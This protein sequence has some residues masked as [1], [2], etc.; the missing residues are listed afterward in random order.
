MD[1]S[2]LHQ[3]RS[4]AIGG[5]VGE[6]QQW[7]DDKNLAR[8]LGG[9]TATAAFH[10]VLAFSGKSTASVLGKKDLVV[11]KHIHTYAVSNGQ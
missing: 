6:L 8:I 10:Y 3:L 5:G 1:W 11:N 7:D 2:P 4:T 9:G